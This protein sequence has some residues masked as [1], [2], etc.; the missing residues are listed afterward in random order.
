MRI[1]LD[2]IRSLLE[3]MDN[4]ALLASISDLQIAAAN[5]NACRLSG[6]AA[7][8]LE[9]KALRVLFPNIV[10]RHEML[11][12]FQELSQH[13]IET[14][15]LTRAQGRLPVSVQATPLKPNEQWCLFTI[16]SI[17][18]IQQRKTEQERRLTEWQSYS[19]ILEAANYKDLQTALNE[20]FSAGSKFVISN[21]LIAYLGDQQ[22]PKLK[23]FSSWG[24]AHVFPDEISSRDAHALINMPLWVHGQR[25]IVTMAHQIAQAAGFKHLATAP[26]GDAGAWVGLILS[27]GSNLPQGKELPA[28][29]GILANAVT[30]AVQVAVR[31]SNLQSALDASKGELTYTHALRDA[32]HDGAVLVSEEYRVLE[33]NPAAE[34]ILGYTNLEALDHP[35]ENI[36]IGSDRIIPAIQ[37]AL[38]GIPTPNLGNAR[39]HRRD[40]SIFPASIQAAPVKYAQG[41]GAA[42][43]IIRD[44]S[45]HESI[46]LQTQQLEQRALL[47]EVT[48]VFAHEVRNPINNISTGLQLMAMNTPEE[49]KDRREQIS[50]LQ[51]DCN[52]L[53][54]LMESVLTFSRTGNYSFTPILLES[55]LERIL[56]RWRPR[57][58][59]NNVQHH[60]QIQPG[61][62]AI[63]GDQRALEQVFTNLISNALEA[64]GTPGGTL[65]I[66]ISSEQSPGGRLVVQVDVSDTGPGIPEEIRERIFEPFFSTRPTGTGLGLSITKQ[67]ITAHR[68]SIHLTTFP[69][70]TV[71]HVRLPAIDDNLETNL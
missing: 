43:L 40:G 38:R 22:E 57:L 52:R 55:V 51:Q 25:K 68:G 47:G 42:L 53:T 54:E 46:R 30:L 6:Y 4:A 50:R 70:G 61:T 2:E 18:S 10:G 66:K 7:E 12:V 41:R 45:E 35:V 64:M 1:T 44:V 48:A 15:L 31:I 36:L 49:D 8:E 62:P 11:T 39:L 13:A 16:E 69:G 5:T 24:Q 60:M 71:F 17:D 65:A 27:A 9:G 63:M 23:R 34:Y 19:K 28:R 32:I 29:M 3:T 56:T 21:C 59:K 58:N 37:M 20:I 33:I 26:I 67:I 14:V